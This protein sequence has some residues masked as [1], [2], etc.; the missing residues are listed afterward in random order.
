MIAE[1]A[2]Y[3]ELIR[4]LDACRRD[5]ARHSQDARHVASPPPLG[6]RLLAVIAIVSCAAGAALA[7]RV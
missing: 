6:V 7:R 3:P 2:P 5:E 1:L 4:M